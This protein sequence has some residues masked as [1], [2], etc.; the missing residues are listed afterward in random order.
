MVCAKCARP[1][2]LLAGCEGEVIAYIEKRKTGY[3]VHYTDPKGRHRAEFF[4]LKDDAKGR[5]AELEHK[6]RIRS[7]VDPA[8]GAESLSDF[9][10]GFLAT[11]DVRPS[12]RRLYATHGRLYL[13][14][15]L[16]DRP[17]GSLR[18]SDVSEF[19]AVMRADGVGG[20]TVE[21]AFRLLRRV[22]NHAVFEERIASNPAAG[23]KVRAPK[24]RDARFMSAEEVERLAEAID[25][26][27]RVLV[28]LGC[29]CGPRIGEMAFL[30]VRHLD[31]VHHRIHIVGSAGRDGGKRIEGPT[32]TGKERA[33]AVP[34]DIWH[35]LVE[36]LEAFGNSRDPESYVF[37]SRRDLP[38]RADVFRKVF[39][40]AAEKAHIAPSPVVHDMRHTAASLMAQQGYSLLQAA[41]VLGHS[42]VFMTSHYSHLFPEDLDQQAAR[43][44]EARAEARRKISEAKVVQFP[45][46]AG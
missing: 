11:V 17:I 30:R 3:R 22:L 20:S 34:A 41:Q 25:S 36:H 38:L 7:Y 24:P 9:F 14:P 6:L 21:H 13:K 28:L 1:D 44:T 8:L 39:G 26:R 18:R 27:F 46:K 40:E 42:T 19:L 31:F 45:S 37:A 33:V 12:T 23:H 16:G 2:I 10:D 4:R 35:E 29:W 43:L 15:L 5:K 32:K